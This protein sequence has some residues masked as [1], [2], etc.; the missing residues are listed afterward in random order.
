MNSLNRPTPAPLRGGERAA[1]TPFAG[2][3]LGGVGVGSLQRFA[4]NL[5]RH[6]LSLNLAKGAR[7]SCRFNV[8]PSN[9][10]EKQETSDMPKLKRPA[11]V[12]PKRRYGATRR[13]KGGT[14]YLRLRL[15]SSIRV[16]ILEV[17]ATHEPHHDDG[18][19]ALPRRPDIGFPPHRM[20]Y[21]Y[22]PSRP[23]ES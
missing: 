3:L 5:W 7:H 18:R 9:A 20:P 14:P 19:A 15:I 23:L 1:D 10:S 17:F 8:N 4:S 11:A 12:A 16:P 13:R 6:P 2:P 22:I 21:S